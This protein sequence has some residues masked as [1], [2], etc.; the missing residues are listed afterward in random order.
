MNTYIYFM[1]KCDLNTLVLSQI[2][3]LWKSSKSTNSTPNTI[4]TVFDVNTFV[5][6]NTKGPWTSKLI[7][8]GGTLVVLRVV[9]SNVQR[10]MAN[11]TGLKASS[12]SVIM[13]VIWWVQNQTL[14]QIKDQYL[15]QWYILI[16]S[17]TLA[18]H[19]VPSG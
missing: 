3:I 19:R 7:I 11:L 14:K 4:G 8:S 12:T 9:L 5:G 10:C 1:L 16:P 13:L 2:T 6:T 17:L 15:K 18:G